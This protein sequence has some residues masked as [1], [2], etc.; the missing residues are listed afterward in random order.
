MRP[1]NSS[2][3]FIF[4]NNEELFFKKKVSCWVELFYNRPTRLN[5]ASDLM[6]STLFTPHPELH[7]NNCLTG[8]FR[9]MSFSLEFARGEGW[10]KFFER[11]P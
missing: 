2:H 8:S 5:I 9:G 7:I 10:G 6:L 3:A 4:E 1:S 11:N